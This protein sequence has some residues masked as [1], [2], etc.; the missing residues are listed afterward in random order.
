MCIYLMFVFSSVQ[1]LSRVWLFVTP[2]TVACQAL[3]QVSPTQGWN[4]GF[5]HCRQILPP[6]EPPGKPKNTGVGQSL[7]QWIFWPSNRTRVS[8]IV[9]GFFTVWATRETVYNGKDWGN[10]LWGFSTGNIAKL[11]FEKKIKEMYYRIMPSRYL[12]MSVIKV[13]FQDFGM[14]FVF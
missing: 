3:L 11:S 9:G 7:L 14:L 2:R 6:S 13:I 1:S 4:P 12:M 5:P 8:R 10:Y